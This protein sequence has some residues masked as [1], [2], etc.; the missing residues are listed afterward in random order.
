MRTRAIR[1]ICAVFL[2]GIAMKTAGQSEPSH[3]VRPAELQSL[4]GRADK[5]VVH[6]GTPILTLDS[7]G[8]SRALYSS[9][10]SKDLSELNQAIAVRSPKSWFLCA[11]VAPVEIV[12]YREEEQLGVIV[13][14]EDLSIGLSTWSCDARLLSR[15]RLLKWFDNRGIAGPRRAFQDQLARERADHTASE[16]WLRAMTPGVRT[17]WP[18]VMDNPSWFQEPGQA[19]QASAAVLKPE[20][21]QEI[22]DTSQRILWLFG[23][24]GSGKGPWSGFP[25]YEDVVSELLLGYQ[26]AELMI[27]LQSAP[28]TGSQMEGAARFFCGY[29]YGYRFRE[30]GDNRLIEQIP[31]DIK[32]TLLEHELR[33]SQPDNV[34]RAAKAFGKP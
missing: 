13:V 28:L 26:P 27:A 17:R 33:S 23:W 31:E 2:S 10:N 3:P 19:I 11:C 1:L 25:A 21:L 15:E 20:L 6:D 30:P 22:P 5:V 16:R 34:K 12:L 4:I 29:I 9:V 8:K 14:Y 32:M 24:F 7:V 18:K